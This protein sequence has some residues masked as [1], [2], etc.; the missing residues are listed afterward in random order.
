MRL[1]SRLRFRLRALRRG[2][3][4]QDLD[5]ELQFHLEQQAAAYEREGLPPVEARAAARRDFGSASVAAE[6]CRDAHGVRLWLDAGRDV[7]FGWRTALRAPG[8]MAA[9]VV[10]LA[11]GLGAAT[12]MFS[13][14]DA[15]LLRPL[16]FPEQERLIR[17]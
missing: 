9:A 15:V 5:D 11:L 6:A 14:I 2:A 13:V 12:S 16:P 8:T 17:A 10:T 3:A 1:L 7:R 4:Q